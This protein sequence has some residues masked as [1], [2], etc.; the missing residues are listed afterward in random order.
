MMPFKCTFNIVLAS[1]LLTIGIMPATAA[2]LV[3]GSEQSVSF[4]GDYQDFDIPV[5]NP[6]DFIRFTVYGADGGDAVA[7]GDSQ[8]RADGGSGATVKAVFRIGTAPEALEPGGTIRFVVGQKGGDRYQLNG[9]T[10][11]AGGGGG[12]SGV[13]YRPPGATSSDC[14]DGW[15]VIAAAGGGGGAYQSTYLG[16]CKA[17]HPGGNARTS[18]CG[19]NGGG[20]NGGAGGCNGQAG[21]SG[22]SGYGQ[23]GAGAYENSEGSEKGCPDGGFAG[24]GT[25][26]GAD[27]GWGF[28][29]GGAGRIGG[30]AQPG[31]GG[32]GG[33]SGGGGGRINREGGGGGS[34]VPV[35]AIASTKSTGN[36]G[37]SDGEVL[38]LCTYAGDSCFSANDCDANGVP[39]DCDLH[40]FGRLNDFEGAAIPPTLY[41]TA[42]INNDSV[43]LTSA[44]PF[45]KGSAI[46]EPVTSELI[47]AFTVEFDYLMGGGNGADGM[48]FALIDA[49]ASDNTLLFN[50]KGGDHPLVVSLDTYQG[51]AAGGNHAEI[52]SY[53]ESIDRVQV[54]HRLDNNQW[55]HAHV[56]FE[57]GALTLILDDGFFNT[58]TVFDAVDVPGFTPIRAQY[59]FGARTGAATNNHRVDNVYFRVAG[60]NDCDLNEVPDNC[61]SDSDHDGTPNTCEDDD[62]DGVP[63]FEDQCPENDDNEDFDQ[64]GVADRCDPCPYDE[65]DDSDGDGVCDSDDICPDADDSVSDDDGDGVC[66][67]NDICPGND[68]NG[69]DTDGDSLPDACDTCPGERNVWNATQKTYH[70]TIALAIASAEDNDVIELGPCT[71]H[72]TVVQNTP[73]TFTIRGQGPDLTI[74]DGGQANRILDLF[75]PNLTIENLTLRNGMAND[76]GAAKTQ[77]GNVTF[78][79][80]IFENNGDGTTQTGA[81]YVGTGRADFERCVFRENGSSDT[82]NSA[83][84]VLAE[85]GEVYFRNCLFHSERS[86]RHVLNVRVDPGLLPT[87]RATLL[88]C[89][90]ADFDGSHFI[91][92]RSSGTT[93]FAI[94]SVFDGSAGTI[95]AGS[96]V[97]QGIVR[98]LYPGATGD[99]L[100]GEPTFVD[101][102]NGDFR[103]VAGSLGID[104]ADHDTY[105]AADGGA[106]DLNDDPRTHDD[107]GTDDTGSGAVT[108]LDMGAFEF[109]G[110]TIIDCNSNG[111][112]DA[113]DIAEGTSAD[114]NGDMVPDDCELVGNDCNANGIPDDCDIASGTSEDCNTNGVPDYCDVTFGTVANSPVPAQ[115]NSNAATDTRDDYDPQ[116][117][118]DGAGNW[119]AVWETRD[120][121]GGTIGLDS[122]IL[123]ARSADNGT[124]WS[125]VAPLNSN[126]ATDD[127]SDTYDI[128]PQVTTDG[129][130]NWIAVWSSSHDF[131]GTIGAD[132]DILFSRSTDNGASWSPA[133]P[134]NSN[135]ATDTG[136]DSH[137]KLTTD[138]AG[139]WIA[140]WESSE[141]LG[142]AIGDDSDILYARST[143]EGA[144]W[145]AP[146]PLNTDAATDGEHE[147]AQELTTDGAGTWIAVWLSNETVGGIDGD[148]DILYSRSTDAG[149]SWSDPT[150]LNSNAAIDSE[151]ELAPQLTTDGAGNW[152]AVWYSGDALGGT[153]G[154]D[155]DIFYSRSTDGGNTWS[156]L[157]PLN[158][159][160]ATDSSSDDGA[161]LATD[162]AGHWTAVWSSKSNIGSTIGNDR[163]LLYAQSADN[164]ATWSAPAPFNANADTDAR[165]D[166]QPQLKT[167][168]AGTWIAAW[169]SRDELGG[170]IGTDTDILWTRFS[171]SID[172]NE[173]GVP[174]ECEITCGVGGD[175]DADGDVD[176]DDYA[177][178][179]DCLNGPAGGLAPNCACS[180]LDGDGDV[181]MLDFATFQ[182]SFTGE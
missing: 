60:H 95:D 49:D 65:F 123:F 67:W 76:G 173:N 19:G 103:L 42:V 141:T 118:C 9:T 24:S 150:T 164:G 96:A 17:K 40:S 168:G 13:L 105:L 57:D 5:T 14:G 27:G 151:D 117:T 43:R 58:T 55:Q 148:D 36:N 143:D 121:L 99:N 171:Q 35:G 133:A 20:S 97:S 110:T 153:I 18:T 158:A 167:D 107:T 16:F 111:V 52:L 86:P 100:E 8:C 160:A 41:G 102:T 120:D 26:F 159:N 68:D 174:D 69:P 170:T 161:R 119:V 79:N 145:S 63:N 176:L 30:I 104:A 163:D 28:G 180:D 21:E 93:L 181:D 140:L 131:G 177:R 115:L 129:A 6:P 179:A 12:G 10:V 124:T 38:Y 144:T 152:I 116:L 126:A 72:E 2:D 155:N 73:A 162:G 122:D 50:E 165:D 113:D 109:Q 7:G 101:A 127:P 62:G 70:P 53:G 23:G 29:G 106:T 182:L 132:S 175:T 85:S 178:F 56:I 1:L 125:A 48:S 90:F 138:G 130:G 31:A 82:G 4:T 94:N 134:L 128:S 92:A 78:R 169:M 47:D 142:G 46:F 146:A 71:F 135:A 44:I 166:Y 33:Y 37:R 112:N 32:G 61:Q 59:G 172:R 54:P 45:L 91:R 64:D 11:A 39:D 139:T 34:F 114:C 108:H 77:L 154:D 157:A 136:S 98:C 149:A 3:V 80:C 156:D 66:N 22:G 81:V 15:A 25:T 75:N 137:P 88:N 51:D 83:S 87:A 74:L 147:Y 89:T 84:S